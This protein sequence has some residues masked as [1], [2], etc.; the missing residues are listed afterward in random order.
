MS[1]KHG[2]Q[3]GIKPSFIRQ[4]GGKMHLVFICVTFQIEDFKKL[5]WSTRSS[6]RMSGLFI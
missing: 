5:T 1:L 6:K 4:C 2:Q 3:N